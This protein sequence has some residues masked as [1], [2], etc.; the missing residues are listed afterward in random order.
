M[1]TVLDIAAGM[2][3]IDTSDDKKKENQT[4]NHVHG[5]C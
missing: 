2:Q 3:D 4:L 1:N 5:Q